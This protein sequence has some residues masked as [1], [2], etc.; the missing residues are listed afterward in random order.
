MSKLS[1]D[2]KKCCMMTI[3]EGNMVLVLQLVIFYIIN[4]SVIYLLSAKLIN[5]SKMSDI[6]RNALI[7]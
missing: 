2:T 1:L 3:E 6:S 4:E 5:W 7:S